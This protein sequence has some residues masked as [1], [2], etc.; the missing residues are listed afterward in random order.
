MPR[1]VFPRPDNRER[2]E[3]GSTKCPMSGCWLWEKSTSKGYGQ[4][5]IKNR[6]YRSHR[7]SYEA[8]VGPIP[9][10]LHVCHRCDNRL[11]VN[12][13][14]LFVG[15]HA[16]NMAD[17]ARKERNTG[18]GKKNTKL[19]AEAV[20]DIRR[21][22]ANGECTASIAERYGVHRGNINNIA[23]YRSWRWA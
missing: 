19:T 16:D 4:M 17:M 6:L 12:P 7:V 3:A 10:G 20:R 1:G 8:F 5:T 15:T 22:V 2:I 21:R 23:A 14:H 18:E 9:N 11:C 13:A